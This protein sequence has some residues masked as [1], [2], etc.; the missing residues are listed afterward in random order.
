MG[1]GMKAHLAAL[2]L[3]GLAA[4]WLGCLAGWA[5]CE[6]RLLKH[7]QPP[8]P[9]PPHT[10]QLEG[11][12][13]RPSSPRP[14]SRRAWRAFL[15]CFLLLVFASPAQAAEPGRTPSAPTGN[16]SAS[17]VP[18]DPARRYPGYTITLVQLPPEHLAQACLALGSPAEYNACF[19]PALGIVFFRPG[20]WCG[21]AHELLHAL[22]WV[23][24]GPD[25]TCDG[26]HPR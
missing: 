11:R 23:H 20:D 25:A 14:A 8:P 10:P 24:G 19:A 7:F 2:A 6:W 26:R 18:L 3:Y 15:A 9:P 21:L 12:G 1:V 4:F 22:G 16:W 13:G 17:I 5:L